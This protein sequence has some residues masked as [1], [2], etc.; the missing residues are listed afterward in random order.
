MEKAV[1]EL[2]ANVPGVHVLG[3]AVI[4]GRED[5]EVVGLPEADVVGS[6]DDIDEEEGL[7]CAVTVTVRDVVDVM[8]LDDA[9]V[10]LEAL[11]VEGIIVVE[12][13]SG[14]VGVDGGFML[15]VIV[16]KDKGIEVVDAVELV[17]GESVVGLIEVEEGEAEGA[18]TPGLFERAPLQVN[19]SPVWE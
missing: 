1:A 4:E 7:G 6:T 3:I 9:A 5:E 13:E 8:A 14:V 16:V 10:P 12:F 2:Q 15:D 19:P 18:K 17:E 11:V